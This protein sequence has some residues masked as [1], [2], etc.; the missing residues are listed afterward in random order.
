MSCPVIYL[1]ALLQRGFNKGIEIPVQHLL[2][3]GGFDACAQVFDAT[4]I[5]HVR[6]DLVSPTHIRFAI[7]KLLLLFHAFAHFKVIEL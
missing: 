5:Q 1:H 7:L 6:A 2:G 4:L 3:I